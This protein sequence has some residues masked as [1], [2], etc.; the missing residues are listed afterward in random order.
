MN[1]SP[2]TDQQYE[3][4]VRSINNEVPLDDID[5]AKKA[6]IINEMIDRQ[7]LQ[8]YAIKWGLDKEARLAIALDLQQQLLLSLAEKKNILENDIK[9]TEQQLKDRYELEK[10]K[11]YPI[12]YHI[13][14]INVASEDEAKSIIEKLDKD[15]DFSALATK[16]SLDK[17]KE[18]GGDL[19]WVQKTSI[20][21]QIFENIAK[22]DKGSYSKIPVQTQPGWQIIKLVDSRAVTFLDFEQAKKRLHPALQ[23]ELLMQKIAAMRDAAKIEFEKM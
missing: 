5:Q 9:V 18:N 23:R 3:V 13:Q 15:G 1:G 19:G 14:H 17:S 6:Q 16:F 10:E 12:E 20:L 8:Q 21:P 4:F 7:L 2:I 11:A 22:L